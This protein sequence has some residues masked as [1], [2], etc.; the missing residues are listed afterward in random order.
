MHDCEYFL[1]HNVKF[2]THILPS[3]YPHPLSFSKKCT[4]RKNRKHHINFSAV[5]SQS[6]ES[7]FTHEISLACQIFFP[8]FHVINERQQPA[9][10]RAFHLFTGRL[11]TRDEIH[12]DANN[13]LTVGKNGNC[14]ESHQLIKMHL[15]CASTVTR[16]TKLELV[17]F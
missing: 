17:G 11:L 9:A 13:V 14:I 15:F 16:G 3:P 2:L 7:F 12:S 10:S 5:V 6:S 4:R 8:P 1:H